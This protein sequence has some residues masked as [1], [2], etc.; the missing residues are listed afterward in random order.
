MTQND[1]LSTEIH[2]LHPRPLAVI[3]LRI[4]WVVRTFLWAIVAMLLRQGLA[5]E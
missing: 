1:R 4:P 3:S 2:F 5:A